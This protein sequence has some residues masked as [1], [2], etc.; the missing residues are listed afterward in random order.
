MKS[1]RGYA[2]LRQIQIRGETHRSQDHST[3]T[4]VKR[5]NVSRYPDVVIAC[6]EK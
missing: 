6:A 4:N 3:F 1:R 2:V 5:M